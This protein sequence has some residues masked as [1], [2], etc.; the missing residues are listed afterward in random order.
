MQDATF[1]AAMFSTFIITQ[2]ILISTVVG[3]SHISL[4]KIHKKNKRLRKLSTQLSITN[5]HKEKFLTSISHE[6]RT[7]LN[8]INGYLNLLNQRHDL[9]LEV[10]EQISNASTSSSQLLVTINNLIDYSEIHQNTMTLTMRQVNLP[11]LIKNAAQIF[12]A[13]AA[14]KNIGY[15][16]DIDADM[17]QLATVDPQR[18]MQILINLLDNA[19]KFTNSG[20]IKLTAQY[21]AGVESNNLIYIKIQDTGLGI[22]ENRLEYIFDPFHQ[23]RMLDHYNQD[24]ALS[25][26]GLGLSIVKGILKLWKGDIQLESKFESG[27]TIHIKIPFIVE[28]PASRNID[29]ENIFIHPKIKPLRI[30][31]VDDHAMNRM[32]ATATI[33][34]KIPR[35]II[36]Q[37]DNGNQAL[38]MMAT[39]EYDIVLLDIFM[40]D[41]DG[42]NVLKLIRKN[43]SEP[44]RSTKS[45][46]FTANLDADV[47][48]K[49][50]DAGFNGFISKPFTADDLIHAIYALIEQ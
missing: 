41:I 11:L 39:T 3:I 48:Q 24:I 16:C 17:P 6:M 13:K 10:R 28:S 33:R 9:P 14:K 43:Y 38:Q 36:E 2:T 37:A 27:T 40:P 31:V 49:C 12:E 23:T 45:I 5:G 35:C 8:S 18:M 47:K 34:Q 30:L 44:Y 20:F 15:I 21:I 25:G 50:L 29:S 22:P 32:L 42:I 46:A 7:P 19:L 26:N 4:R 1:A